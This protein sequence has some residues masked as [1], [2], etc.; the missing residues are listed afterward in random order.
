ME[1]KQ[2]KTNRRLLEYVSWD[3]R[4]LRNN[5]T[6]FVFIFQTSNYFL[7]EINSAFCSIELQNILVILNIIKKS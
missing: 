4:G 5:F 3:D 7:W 1:L 6:M 2:D